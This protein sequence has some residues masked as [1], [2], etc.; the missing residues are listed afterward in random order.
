MKKKILFVI[1]TLGGG[2]AEKVL[3]NLVNALD[4]KKYEVEIKTL[5]ENNTNLQFLNPDIKISSFLKKQFKG[6]TYIFKLFSPTFLYK[7]I[8]GKKYDVVISYLEG[9]GERVV[10]GSPFKETKLINWVHGEQ[11][12]LKTASHS[13]RT[14]KEYQ[15]CLDK[16]HFTVCVSSTVKKDL[17]NIVKIKHPTK[18][19]YNTLDLEH[20]IN[21]S[22]EK[23][24][25]NPFKDG[26]N[27]ITSGRLIPIKGFDR[28]IE[29]HSKLIREGLAH[30]LY[31][32][33]EGEEKK[34]LIKECDALGV[35]DSVIFLGFHSNP[36]KFISNADVFVCSSRSEGFSTAVSEAIILGKPVISTLCSG[37][38]ELLGKNNEYGIIVE[39]SEKGIYEGLKTIL[40]DISKIEFYSKKS[41]E[42]KE[43]FS[44][45]MTV[46]EVENLL[47]S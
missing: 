7:I 9:P 16:F 19:I 21:K 2:G 46:K 29:V 35:R 43:F 13:Y 18:I 4:K 45:K 28:L 8:I 32:L 12:N 34:Q 17:E 47:D 40:K 38:E 37:A 23:I 26:I 14:A 24:R 1:P 30:N 31:I 6:N 27:I 44:P 11:H 22:K 10:S 42:R 15:K 25:L 3:V 5:F 33:G 36:Y 41:L 20:I 39:N